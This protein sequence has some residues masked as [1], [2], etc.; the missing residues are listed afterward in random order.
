MSEAKKGRTPWN[1]GMKL[2]P[3]SPETRRKIRESHTGM[4]LSPEHCRN[5]SESKKGE[6]N[7]HYGKETSLE[8]RKKISD[9]KKGKKHT[10][11]SRRKMSDAQK[12]RKISLGHRRKLS[13]AK[14]GKKLSLETCRKMS[15]A[16]RGEK[17]HFW[18]GGISFEPYPPEF[19]GTLKR[20]IKERDNYTCQ[21]PRCDHTNTILDVHHIDYNKENKHPSNL[22]TLCH[23]CHSKTNIRRAY[24]TAFLSARVR[25]IITLEAFGLVEE[26]KT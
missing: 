23:S 15:G 6:K 3:R 10:L 11:K 14:K 17:C 24:W 1:K 7:P 26:L 12:G 20:L 13:D 9:A 5:I 21:N 25:P 4:K 19:N 2:Y 18:R 22:I 8:T 16:H